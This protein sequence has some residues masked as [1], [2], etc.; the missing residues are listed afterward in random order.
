MHVCCVSFTGPA[1]AVATCHACKLNVHVSRDVNPGG[2]EGR[3]PI[4]GHVLLP[5]QGSQHECPQSFH[6]NSYKGEWQK[7]T[8]KCSRLLATL[9]KCCVWLQCLGT[10]SPEVTLIHSV[11]SS[12]R[13]RDSGVFKGLGA[14]CY[15]APSAKQ[16]KYLWFSAFP[17]FRKAGQ[18]AACI[19]RPKAR[20]HCVSASGRGVGASPPHP[21]IGGFSGGPRW[22]LRSQTAVIGSR[23]AHFCQI[24]NTWLVRVGDDGEQ[25]ETVAESARCTV[26]CVTIQD[27]IWQVM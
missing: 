4:F 19:E 17:H 12:R 14:W 13:V 2:G 15:D 25:V 10:P 24:L 1:S 20:W 16:H 18:F 26:N 8:K 7:K 5:S 23:S 21:L 9:Q 6:W 22:G 3:P 27:I 11:W